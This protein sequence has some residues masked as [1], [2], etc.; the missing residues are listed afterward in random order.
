MILYSTTVLSKIH[1][2]NI[3]TGLSQQPCGRAVNQKD[4]R[5]GKI[6]AIKRLDETIL[7]LGGNG[8]N[9]HMSWA[10]DDNQYVS[11]CDGRGWPGMPEAE[12]N[13]RA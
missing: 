6:S 7:R 11:M 3:E 1:R 12:Y 2:R 10:N 4:K 9:W 5:M 8:D 13:S